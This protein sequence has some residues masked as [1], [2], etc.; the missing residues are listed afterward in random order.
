MNETNTNKK[1]EY[2]PN[3]GFWPAKSGNGYTVFVDAG[4]RSE[5]ER[6]LSAATEGTRLYL[7]QPK[8]DNKKAP[9]FRINVLPKEEA[10]SNDDSV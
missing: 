3:I 6:L 4:T 2:P 1:T 8:S 5:L 10:Q 7:S 9:A